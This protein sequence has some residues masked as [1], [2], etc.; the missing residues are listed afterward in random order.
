MALITCPDCQ[1]QM[2]SSAK[3][4]PNCGKPN[5]LSNSTIEKTSK[6]IKMLLLIGWV[7]LIASFIIYGF[8]NRDTAPCNAALCAFFLSIL[9]GER[10]VKKIL[11]TRSCLISCPNM[12]VTAPGFS[13][14]Y[15]L[16]NPLQ[17][18]NCSRNPSKRLNVFSKPL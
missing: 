8:S 9:R 11:N 5:T 4:C 7:V 18:E 6:S 2:S 17:G 14:L 10:I 16:R 1:R 15:T 12:Q 3:E 13:N